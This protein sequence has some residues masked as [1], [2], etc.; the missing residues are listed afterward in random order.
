MSSK[1]EADIT[2][3]NSVSEGIRVTGGDTAPSDAAACDLSDALDCLR[4]WFAIR[5][6]DGRK[7]ALDGLSRIVED[8]RR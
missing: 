5:T 8:E 7:R 3:P 4:F 1:R 2:N 6:D